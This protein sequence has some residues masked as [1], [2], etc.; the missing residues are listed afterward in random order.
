MDGLP[1][2]VTACPRI[3]MG[4]LD[5]AGATARSYGGCG[6][7]VS[8]LAVEVSVSPGEDLRFEAGCEL[9]SSAMS[10]VSALLARVREHSPAVTGCVEVLR[11][12]PEHVG[13]G[14]KTALL[15]SVLKALQLV[16]EELLSDTDLVSLSGRGGASGVGVNTFFVGGFVVDAG[17]PQRGDGFL[18]S[19]A[20]QPAGRPL[21]V[22]RADFPLSWRV[23]LFMP[24][25]GRIISG[26]EEVDFFRRNTPLPRLDVLESVACL[27][28]A[29]V[30][31][32]LL[33]DLTMLGF[34][35]GRMCELGFKSRE[36]A[37]QPSSSDLIKGIRSRFR[38]PVGMSSLGPLV[39]AVSDAESRMAEQLRRMAS[40]YGAGYIGE[41]SAANHGYETHGNE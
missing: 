25:D 7:S 35:L 37:F 12:T 19:S 40:E 36:I 6:F 2:R 31:A 18:P 14:S 41:F 33:R 21:M 11:S 27:Y 3:H 28:H 23:H 39:Y 5:L 22:L 26:A 29:V 15:L 16:N 20:L 10:A 34:G 13:L 9:S 17:H 1:I 38:L 32:I 4:L 24:S 8:G 30:P